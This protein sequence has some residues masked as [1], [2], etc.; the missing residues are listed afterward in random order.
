VRVLVAGG[1]GYIGAHVV[2]ALD[3]AGHEPLIVDDFRK[4]DR[5]RAGR[6][7]VDAIALEDTPAL[8]RTFERFRPDGVVH[9]GGYISV[10]ES[11]REPALYW[12]NNLGAGASLLVAA[13]RVPPRV[14][15]FSSTAAVY[16]DAGSNPIPES[17][18]LRPTS[19]YGASKLAFERLLDSAGAAAGPAPGFRCAALRYFNASGANRGWGVGEA[20]DPEEHLIPRVIRMLRRGEKVTVYGNDYPTPDGTCVRDYVHVD[21]LASAHVAVLEAD[22]PSPVRFNVGTGKGASVLEVIREVGRQLGVAP[23]VEFLARRP[24]DP[25]SLVADPSALR[26]AVAWTAAHSSLEEIV[27]SA[28]AWELR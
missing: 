11:V 20:H 24:G 28:I 10:G 13:S 16:G 1:A 6:Y 4:S 2:R 23:A 3:A 21:D 7:P 9:L 5:S 26:R 17:A 12:E 27:S 25:P 22:L 19:P 8:T 14:V 18:P 15:L